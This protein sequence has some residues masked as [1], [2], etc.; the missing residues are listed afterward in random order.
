M[1]GFQPEST[2][3]L[4]DFVGFPFHE[5]GSAPLD[6]ARVKSPGA[7]QD[8]LAALTRAIRRGDEQ[9]FTRF[10]DL[11]SFRL[12]KHLLVLA[13]GNDEEA[14]EVLQTVLLKLSKRFQ[15]FDD[16]TR[17][18]AWLRKVARNAFVDH[19]RKHSRAPD[20]ISI[21]ALRLEPSD[22][23][24]DEHR[25]SAAL[26]KA[27]DE[28]PPAD[29]ELMRAVYLDGQPLQQIA[30]ENGQTYKAIESQLA[31]LRRKVKD[32]ILNHLRHEE[33]S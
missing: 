15:V 2:A 31:R 7:A 28:L 6:P 12:Y 16:E 27:L 13:R 21:E 5:A 22:A 26:R 23:L 20:I 9:A 32:R 24:P 33:R 29:R 25:L 10:Y 18:W 17:L 3:R 19:C 1:P 30:D 4:S 14:R 11:Y 8:D